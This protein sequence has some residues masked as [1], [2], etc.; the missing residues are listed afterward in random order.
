[1]CP[2]NEKVIALMRE[3]YFALE[4]KEK[5]DQ[6][7]KK[8]PAFKV[9]HLIF[10]FENEASMLFCPDIVLK[11]AS[12]IDFVE[13]KHMKGTIYIPSSI[14]LSQNGVKTYYKTIGR[15]MEKLSEFCL[16]TANIHVDV[17][18]IIES[19]E[20]EEFMHIFLVFEETNKK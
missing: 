6:T 16:S 3:L 12:Q 20:N 1:M 4:K 11:R 7:Y 19:C 15:I 9:V 17:R 14:T 18:N 5:L 13:K 8:Y 2:P 10:L